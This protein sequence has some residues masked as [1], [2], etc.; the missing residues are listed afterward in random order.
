[1]FNK[2]HQQRIYAHR[3][4]WREKSEQNTEA[5]FAACISEGF[6]IETDLRLKGYGIVLAHST[7]DLK[8]SPPDISQSLFSTKVA[9][10]IK[11]D[12][13]LQ[14]LLDFQAAIIDSG[15]FVFDGSIPEMLIY[16]KAGIPHALRL[17][18]YE[19]EPAWESGILW[20]DGFEDDWWLKDSPIKQHFIGK[21]VIIVSP[22]IHG[23]DP[24]DTWNFI[25]EN[26]Q[27]PNY[28]ISICTDL[29]K[30]FLQRIL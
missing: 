4:I 12:G 17:S 5:A 26:W 16:K 15:S 6:A 14:A 20:I 8:N 21:K 23:R 25:L 19:R 9:L 13:L 22:E 24:A 7:D 28:E 1:M 27:N 2:N 29:P 10:N 30:T 11:E 18:E 3:G